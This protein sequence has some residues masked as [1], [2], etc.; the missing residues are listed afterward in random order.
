MQQEIVIFSKYGHLGG[1]FVLVLY[2]F[3]DIMGIFLFLKLIIV[4]LL[5]NDIEGL[6]GI[7]ITFHR[8]LGDNT[9]ILNKLLNR[10]Q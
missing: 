9:F 1:D 6:F 10:L 2:F 7:Y 4:A 3:V 8:G 5:A